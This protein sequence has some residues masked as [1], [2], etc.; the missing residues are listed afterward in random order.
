ME[1]RGKLEERETGC[2]RAKGARE[3]SKLGRRGFGM[4]QGLQS[5]HELEELTAFVR[6]IRDES[7]R[8]R[9]GSFPA[10]TEPGGG[11]VSITQE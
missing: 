9:E 11:G 4:T 7:R 2:R 5:P 10:D 6:V 1:G 3:R 8:K